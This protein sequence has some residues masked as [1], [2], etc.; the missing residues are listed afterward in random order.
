MTTMMTTTTYKLTAYM[1]FIKEVFACFK[2]N[3]KPS[4]KKQYMQF[5]KE[6]DCF[7]VYMRVMREQKQWVANNQG[8]VRVDTA[9]V[10]INGRSVKHLLKD[11]DHIFGK[12]VKVKINPDLQTM[13]CFQ[14]S[15]F[16][17]EN[18]GWKRVAGFNITACR[19]GG[20]I[21]LE[22]HS[23]NEKDGKLVDYTK[24]FDNQ[25][26]K[27]F[28]PF[29]TDTPAVH[30]KKYMGIDQFNK[31][32]SSCKCGINWGSNPHGVKSI[33]DMPDFHG[34]IN[35]ACRIVMHFCD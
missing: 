5:V 20:L 4:M 27:W 15:Q 21:C 3:M 8:K 13:M 33:T 17:E 7:D 26:H 10:N 32:K 35:Q 25:T 31:G 28:I 16:L 18:Y 34:R 12:P 9:G 23:L 2:R 14:N 22:I 11:A 1:Q 29:K 19:C 6:H 24:D 30:L